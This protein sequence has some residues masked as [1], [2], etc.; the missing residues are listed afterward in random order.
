ML[1]FG[2]DQ[3]VNV[4]HIPAVI[5]AKEIR[6]ALLQRILNEAPQHKP[7]SPHYLDLIEREDL[8]AQIRTIS[9]EVFALKARRGGGGGAYR[10][11][12]HLNSPAFA[13][14]P[15]AW[16]YI[17][18]GTLHGISQTYLRPRHWPEFCLCLTAADFDE[19]SRN[20]LVRDTERENGVDASTLL[21]RAR[22]SGVLQKFAIACR[23]FLSRL[24]MKEE[25]ERER[26]TERDGSGHFGGGC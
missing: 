15:D 1:P 17:D 12:S 20:K 10:H 5:L 26:E 19:L 14:V 22:A 9:F 6:G 7:G 21:Y 13:L 18:A 23:L 24:S 3:R 2:E 11:P 25:L 4:H 16:P 8:A